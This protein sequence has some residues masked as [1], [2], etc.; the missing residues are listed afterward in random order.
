MHTQI[1]S[2]AK[3][4]FQYWTYS[5]CWTAKSTLE[6]KTDQEQTLHWSR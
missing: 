5:R 6:T 1:K 2:Y 3:R 4:M